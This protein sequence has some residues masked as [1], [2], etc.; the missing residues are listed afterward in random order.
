MIYFTLFLIPIYKQITWK[1][2][3]TCWIYTD[4]LFN[5]IFKSFQFKFIRILLEDGCSLIYSEQTTTFLLFPAVL[6]AACISIFCHRVILWNFA[7]L[8][9]GSVQHFASSKDKLIGKFQITE[10]CRGKVTKFVFMR[11]LRSRFTTQGFWY[12]DV[13]WLVKPE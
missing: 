4:F 10:G 7:I 6:D 3:R 9:F 13:N 2:I 11:N 1:E 12:K 8:S 5:D